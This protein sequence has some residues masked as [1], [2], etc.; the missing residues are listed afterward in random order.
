MRRTIAALC[1]YDDQ[2]LGK[3][4]SERLRDE[5]GVDLIAQNLVACWFKRR[6]GY[7]ES[8][9][10]RLLLVFKMLI[11]AFDFRK[12]VSVS[13]KEPR[14]IKDLPC[15]YGQGWDNKVELQGWKSA[16]D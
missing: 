13:T 16:L 10:F 2:V 5:N 8:S 1:A 6:V 14:R 11:L 4:L 15:L 7:R 12:S 3:Y 9:V